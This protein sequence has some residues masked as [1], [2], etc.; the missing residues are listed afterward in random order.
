[1]SSEFKN[2]KKIDTMFQMIDFPR[3]EAKPRKKGINMMIDWGLGVEEQRDIIKS[4]GYYIDKAKIAASITAV[5]PKDV[6][7]AKIDMYHEA[8]ISVSPGG[9]FAELTL[10]QDNFEAYL[11]ECKRAGFK[12]I[13][14][15]DN[16][17]KITPENKKKAIRMAIENYGLTVYGEVGR[18][19]GRLTDKIIMRDTALCLDAGCDLVY[20]EAAELFDGDRARDELISRLAKEFGLEKLVFELPVVI[21]PHSSHWAKLKVASKLIATLGTDVNMANI[22]YNELYLYEVTR[23]GMGGSTDHPDGAYKRA[24]F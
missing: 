13:E 3:R 7:K 2:A 1:M 24:G 6:L 12:A 21:I 10:K 19:E 20:L 4:A 5:M 11:A 14:I 9:L 17:L 8:G 15:S 23:L 22:E 16:L 18:K